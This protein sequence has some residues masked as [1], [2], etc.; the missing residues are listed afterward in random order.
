[1]KITRFGFVICLLCCFISGLVGAYSSIYFENHKTGK[2]VLQL[3][4]LELIGSD[5][6]V[7]AVFSVE[8]N[9]NVVLR[10]L[11]K[12]NV[13]ALELGT[14]GVS[15]GN[16]TSNEPSGYLTIRDREGDAT[17]TLSNL[18]RNEG[19]LMFYGPNNREQ[20][21]VG[22]SHYGDVV[23]GHDRG[24]WGISITGPDH[25][26]SGI[27]LFSKDGI[28]KGFTVPLEPPSVTDAK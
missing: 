12:E 18:G 16:A 26:E 22:Y 11:S 23:D 1:M 10:M 3:R 14:G 19:S 20:V 25:Q 8:A 15:T 6:N 27:A 5:K 24:R 21:A 17:S 28:V 4:K 9:G 7:R 13:P 2:D